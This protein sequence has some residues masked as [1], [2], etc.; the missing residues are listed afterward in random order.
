[1]ARFQMMYTNN[2]SGLD[3]VVEA[4]FYRVTRKFF[5]FLVNKEVVRTLKVD[6]VVQI[7]RLDDDEEP[8]EEPEDAV[9]RARRSA[10]AKRIAASKA[11]CPQAGRS[12]SA[13]EPPAG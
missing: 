12:S 10:E 4:D 3:P 5:E 11:Q 7:K 2:R 9:T 6:R 8:A 1:M 13:G